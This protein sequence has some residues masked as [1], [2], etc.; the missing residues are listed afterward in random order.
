MVYFYAKLILRILKTFLSNSFKVIQHW[1]LN[2]VYLMVRNITASLLEPF[3]C[4]VDLSLQHSILPLLFFINFKTNARKAIESSYYYRNS[5]DIHTWNS[6]LSRVCRLQ[7]E[8]HGHSPEAQCLSMEVMEN[9]VQIL[10]TETIIMV[11]LLHKYFSSCKYIHHQFLIRHQ[12]IFILLSS[13]H[14]WWIV[15]M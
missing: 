1:F 10:A 5:A 4:C 12:Q 7:P 14:K 9:S 11:I 6:L 8:N 2:Y 15:V 13:F 3:G